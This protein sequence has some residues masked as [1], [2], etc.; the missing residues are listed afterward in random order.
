MVRRTTAL[1]TLLITFVL[2]G[3]QSE[4]AGRSD[5]SPVAG[6]TINTKFGP[7]TAP[8]DPKRVVALGWGDA[9]TA[10][11]FGVQPVGAADWLAFGGD[12]VGPWADALYTRSPKILG[13]LELSYEDVA[14]LKPDLILDTRAAGDQQRYRKLSKIAPTVGIP[15]GADNYA[16]S[17]EQQVTM[18]GKALDRPD[19]ATQL[20]DDAHDQFAAAA[21]KYPQFKDKTVTVAANSSKGWGAYI[22]STGRVRF[23]EDLGLQNSPTVDAAEP[24]GFS[25]DVSEENLD[26]L[27]AD[28][29]VVMPIGTTGAQI[30][31]NRLFGQLSVVKHGHAM[32][33]DDPT[34]SKAYA[35]DSVLSIRYALNKVAPQLA[36]ALK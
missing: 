19:K 17:M 26:L 28:L 5:P 23:M 6:M 11:A 7:V 12:G 35:V 30:K 25:V 29:L 34:I 1:I 2:V 31:K 3:C 13:T 20:L 32:I 4:P 10:L 18:I 9:E 36:A 24:E 15:K 27:E 22:A 14:A 8:N 21:K 33:L 16:T